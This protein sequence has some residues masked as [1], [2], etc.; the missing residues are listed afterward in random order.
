MKKYTL[1]LLIL[2]TGIQLFAKSPQIENNG[3]EYGDCANG[4]GSKK[5]PEGIYEGFF[6]KGLRHG[7][8]S[9]TLANGKMFIGNWKNDKIEGFGFYNNPNGNPVSEVGYFLDGKLHGK[10]FKLMNDKTVDAGIFE[11][12]VLL[13][14]YEFKDNKLELGCTFGDC[15]NYYGR[16][17]WENGDQFNGFFSNSKMNFGTYTFGNGGTYIGAFDEKGQFTGVAIYVYPNEDYYFGNWKAGKFEGL[18]VYDLVKEQLR[19]VGLWKNHKLV[20]RYKQ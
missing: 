4:Y 11:N 19:D 5:Y 20:K 13:E 1:T 14:F 16:F 2:L 6:S 7:P 12:G 15:E 9:I 3:C 8:G 18:G 10:G 17:K